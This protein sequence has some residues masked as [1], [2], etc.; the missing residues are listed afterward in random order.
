M[1]DMLVNL[2]ELDFKE[3]LI[4][5][6]SIEIMKV[7]AP[8]RRNVIKFIRANFNENFVDEFKVSCSNNPITCFIAVKK[9]NIVGFICYEATAK[10]F[11]GPMGVLGTERRQGIGECLMLRCLESMK[12][13][14]Y[15][16]A[17][18]GYPSEGAIH[19]HERVSKAIMIPASTK[20]VY[21]RTI[22]K[23]DN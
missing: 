9:Y 3:K 8:D 17:I 7:L 22:G 21:T 18:L 12:E 5:D 13:M 20:G 16:Y 19:F 2:Y 14:G 11:V 1:A 4:L 15:A 10:N 23:K 6:S